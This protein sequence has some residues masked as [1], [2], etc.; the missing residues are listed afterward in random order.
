MDW[1][2]ANCDE[3]YW[4]WDKAR[5]MGWCHWSFTTPAAKKCTKFQHLSGVVSANSS[6]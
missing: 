5:G 6:S 2:T 3:C 1:A 4:K